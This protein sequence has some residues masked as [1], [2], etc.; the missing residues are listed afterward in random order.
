MNLFRDFWHWLQKS[1]NKFIRYDL[2]VNSEL[3]L[4]TFSG[5]G[6]V[7]LEHAMTKLTSDNVRAT[8]VDTIPGKYH[9]SSEKSDSICFQCVASDIK[10]LLIDEESPLHMIFVISDKGKIV[11]EHG[12]YEDTISIILLKCHL[13]NKRRMY[14]SVNKPAI[15]FA[16][17]LSCSI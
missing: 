4:V 3:A 10:G 14:Q 1:L 11:E 13:I 9:L 17:L 7:K 15:I 16:P 8:L 5:N 2:P 6:S 12:D